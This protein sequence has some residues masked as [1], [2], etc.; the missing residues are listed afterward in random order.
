MVNNEFGQTPGLRVPLIR[1]VAPGQHGFL[2]YFGRDGLR[3][4]TLSEA[5]AM[6]LA[7]DLAR[8]LGLSVARQTGP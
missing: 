3:I 5:Q 4:E 2:L 1:R 8:E 6:T 7:T